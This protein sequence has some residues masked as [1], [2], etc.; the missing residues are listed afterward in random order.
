VKV[1]PP[2][3]ELRCTNHL[4][5]RISITHLY[6]LSLALSN[7]DATDMRIPSISVSHYQPDQWDPQ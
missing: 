4:E 1:N 3:L 6:R 7:R 5:D 2:K